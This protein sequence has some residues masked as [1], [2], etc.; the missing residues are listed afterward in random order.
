MQNYQ[1]KQKEVINALEKQVIS[2]NLTFSTVSPVADFKNDPRVCLTSVHIPSRDLK[3]KIQNTLIEP[4]QKIS[5]KHF[6]YPNDSLHMTIKNI[7]VISNPPHFNETDIEKAK[8]EFSKVIPKHKSFQTFF[9]RLLLFPNN[10]ALMGTSEEELDN[11]IL[12][13]DQELKN[14]K[15]P[16]DKRYLNPRYFFVNMTLARFSNPPSEEFKQK[17][18][19]F[20]ANINFEPYTINSVTL[21]T[22]NAVFEKRNIIGNWNLQ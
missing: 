14:A 21:L 20:S 2:N 8:E 6:Y 3:N 15:I 5:P 18:K 12:D 1:Q 4:L 11:I 16:D 7:R 19:E 10:L 9:Y 13:L 17:V 22:C